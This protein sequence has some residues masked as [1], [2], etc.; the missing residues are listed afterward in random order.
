[1]PSPR[2]LLFS[3]AKRSKKIASV[4]STHHR[5][6]SHGD[7]IRHTD[8]KKGTHSVPFSSANQ[9]NETAYDSRRTVYAVLGLPTGKVIA[10]ERADGA[11][12]RL[13]VAADGHGLPKNKAYRHTGPY[14][15]QLLD[16]LSLAPG[17]RLEGQRHHR[18][19]RLTRK[20]DADSVEMFF[21]E[22]PG[23]RTLRKDDD[24]DALF[25][26][27]LPALQYGPQVE[28]RRYESFSLLLDDFRSGKLGRITLELPPDGGR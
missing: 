4:T 22:L 6:I 24:G 19:A 11:M 23:A 27:A 14:R 12:F 5:K 17:I 13:A 8:I 1:M 7:R 28:L 25:Q 9:R 15:A 3:K 20:L 10:N 16:T 26:Q 2:A 18:N 21:A